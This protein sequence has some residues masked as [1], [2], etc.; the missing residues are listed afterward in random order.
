MSRR[1]FTGIAIGLLWVLTASAPR[2]T[3]AQ[4]QDGEGAPAAPDG[5]PAEGGPAEEAPAEE[6]PAEEA[7]AKEAPP[8]AA[9]A[10][11]APPEAAPVEQA[12]A[13]EAPAEQPPA[14]HAPQPAP[15]PPVDPARPVL[16]A[17]ALATFVEPVYPP[18]AAEQGLDARVE[19]EL[20]VGID[21]T[22]TDVR[23]VTP[24]GNG[25]DEA[26]LEA[27]RR[28]RFTPASKDGVP[29]PARIR[30]PY[31]FEIREEVVE[32]PPEEEAPPVAQLS[33]VVLG[34]EDD[35]PLKGATVTLTTDAGVEAGT[36]T[37]DEAG[38]FAFED[39]EPGLYTV[40]LEREDRES[41]TVSEYLGADEV[42]E[43]RYRMEETYPTTFGAVARV[44]PPPREVTR[45]SIGKTQ[46][47]RMAGTRG[48]ALRTVELMPGVARPPLGAGALIVRG[49]APQDSLTMFE[50]LPVP[51]LYH[52]GGLTSFINSRL[53]DSIEF[54][55]GNFSAKYGR[56]RGGIVD[57]QAADPSR[58]RVKA[59]ADVNL[60]DTSLLIETPIAENVEF[61]AAVRRSYIDVV[62]ES[63]L[64]SDVSALAAPV[65]YDYQVFTT[66]R[67][68]DNDRLRL[69]VYGSQDELAVLFADPDDV[70]GGG[71][72]FNT[73]FHRAHGSWYRRLSDKVDQ[74][75]EVAVG[76]IDFT[77]G[78]GQGF[79][80]Q[81]QG[82]EIYGRSEWR[83]RV[84]DNVR[85][86]GGLDVY[87][88]PGDFTYF[89]PPIEQSSGN[90]GAQPGATPLSSRGR[91]EVTEEFTVVQPAMYLESD[92]TVDD[93]RLVAGGR[94]DYYGAIDEFAFDPR[95]SS[96]Y[97][98]TDTVSL[99]AGVGMF[100]QPPQFPESNDALGNPDLEATQTLHVGTGVDLDVE[101]TVFIGV[102]GF[103]K[104]LYDVVV[105]TEFGERPSF[106]ND[107]VG[108]VYGL[109]LSAR[110]DPKGSF[111][112]YLSYTFSRSERSVRGGPYELFDFDQP[113]ILTVTGV[114]KVGWGVEA[115]ATFRLVSGNPRTPVVGASF[116]R[117]DGQYSPIYGPLNS[118]RN[119]AFHRLDVRV[120]KLWK[121]HDWKLAAYVDVQNVYNQKNQEGVI[122]S[123]DYADQEPVNGLPFFPNLGLRG[124][125]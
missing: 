116:N 72:D 15:Q 75:V 98:L 39:L 60:I 119:P 46:L 76:S 56:R 86:I 54:Y 28:L 95:V 53:L 40:T 122:Y 64:P 35:G 29:I 2:L 109:E 73:S 4:A 25:F 9:P 100:S 87:A 12:P 61:A 36:R 47:T 59:F 101:E 44:K 105:G 51:L 22:V 94:V 1:F 80:F 112:G 79:K 83:G 123:Y 14:Q 17:P 106:T 111:F 90:P 104:R 124:E 67:P 42:T 20:V 96:H 6:A 38:A 121:F 115:G 91:V 13:E 10:E 88:I 63:L 19:L 108:R 37:T 58:E 30:F 69:M 74:D 49:S 3:H 33:A 24:V 48:D 45:R 57:V 32:P 52:F 71:I 103:Y 102:D 41:V 66:Y 62:F 27:G 110:I 68:N 43:V 84:T 34:H 118:S 31:I 16:R 70:T 11:E 114:Y 97:S 81:L 26:A 113:H 82:T 85:V 21:G 125:L 77:L 50:G 23:V 92:L 78:I 107:G 55:P 89:G 65:Y 120:E 99:K 117:D 7:P 93:L 18:A 8:Q 5:A